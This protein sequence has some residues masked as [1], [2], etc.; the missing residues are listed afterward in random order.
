MR[1]P[2][3]TTRRYADVLSYLGG[4]SFPPAATK[5]VADTLAAAA[6]AD[7]Q[8]DRLDQSVIG[9]S[10]AATTTSSGGSSAAGACYKNVPALYHT[11][12][13]F[14]ALVEDPWAVIEALLSGTRSMPV[15][16]R[17]RT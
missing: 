12:L 17:D 4:L 8:A 6:E 3:V 9:P 13:P 15:E 5:K 2:P 16:L 11:R 7:K 10:A 1:S 14:W